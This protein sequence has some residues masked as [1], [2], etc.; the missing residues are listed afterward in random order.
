MIIHNLEQRSPEWHALRLA[1]ITGTR[2]GKIFKSDNLTLIDELIAEQITGESEFVYINAAM[3]WGIDNEPLAKAA[4]EETL[5][6]EI[7]NCGFIQH[8]ELEYFGMSPDGLLSNNGIYK[9]A[10]EIKCP[11]TKNHV[12]YIR[13]NKVPNDYKYQVYASFLINADQET[14]D[15]I[16][17]D[18]RFKVKPIFIYTTYRND[19]EKELQ[20]T[21]QA[22]LKF[23]EKWMKLYNDIIF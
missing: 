3:Q 8:S 19:I 6:C 5:L 2:L 1:K 23:R 10:I 14:H 7:T 13:Q 20:E 12:Q 11:S 15:F 17:F 16:S 22:L 18:P 9:H 4:Y 21:E